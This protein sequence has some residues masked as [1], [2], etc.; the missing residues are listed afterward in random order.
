MGYLCFKSFPIFDRFQFSPFCTLSF[1][2]KLGFKFS[3]IGNL[4][5]DKLILWE[6]DVCPGI[7]LIAHLALVSSRVL[8]F[9]PIPILS[10][11]LLR[12]LL[13]ILF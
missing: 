2:F 8:Q 6:S 12:I 13:Q 11:N 1:I 5:P 7:A 4:V 10:L 3:S 9:N